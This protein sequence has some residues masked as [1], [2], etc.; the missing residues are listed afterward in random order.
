MI[1]LFVIDVDGMLREWGVSTHFCNSVE[2]ELS[3]YG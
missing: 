1:C 2:W 3:F